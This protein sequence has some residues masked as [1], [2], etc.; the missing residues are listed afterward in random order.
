V[1]HAEALLA[2]GDVA[3][4]RREVQAALNVSER[5]QLRALEAECYY[6][7]ARIDAAE[8]DNAAATRRYGRVVSILDE[9][10]TESGNGDPL[11]RE[12]L[13]AMYDAAAAGAQ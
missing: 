5:L 9:I 7:L 1:R 8:G 2:T 4:A 11:R 12:D 13:R 10:Q 3:A 6:A